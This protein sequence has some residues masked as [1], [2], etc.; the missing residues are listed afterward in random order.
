M[1]SGFDDVSATSTDGRV[2]HRSRCPMS[3]AE[4]VTLVVDPI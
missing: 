2:E 1:P 4:I 3:S